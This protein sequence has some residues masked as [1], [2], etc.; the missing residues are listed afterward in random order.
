M[1]TFASLACPAMSSVGASAAS[2]ASFAFD[3][4]GGC[5]R[6]S[7]AKALTLPVTCLK[8]GS[9]SGATVFGATGGCNSWSADSGAAG[10]A[11]APPP[12]VGAAVGAAPRGPPPTAALARLAAALPSGLTLGTGLVG[13]TGFFG[14]TAAGP[15][16]VFVTASAD[17]G[18]FGPSSSTGI[19]TAL[20]RLRPFSTVS[21]AGSSRR[22][23]RSAAS[24]S[25]TASAPGDLQPGGEQCV[26]RGIAGAAL[27][28]EEAGGANRGTAR[29]AAALRLPSASASL[30]G[31]A[32]RAGSDMAVK[33]TL[34]RPR[35]PG[36]GRT[37]A[38]S[39][40]LPPPP[41]RPDAELD[42]DSSEHR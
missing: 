32:A 10:I 36:A 3:A 31:F 38:P 23:S 14:A 22:T 6:L 13:G 41:A 8:A 5:A 33:P 27:Q 11:V 21:I 40:P 35:P 20:A 16:P 1:S 42:A 4:A 7:L 9:C 25:L 26:D 30:T 39:P 17:G 19:P 12:P 15:K 24:M 2:W 37:F 34:L 18:G 28:R 29:P